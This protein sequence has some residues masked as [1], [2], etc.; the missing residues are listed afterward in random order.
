MRM[1]NVRNLLYRPS[2]I[3]LG[4][5]DYGGESGLDLS[6][7]LTCAR[8]CVASA[9]DTIKLLHSTASRLTGAFWYNIFCLLP[10]EVA[11]LDIY[12]AATVLLGARL[13]LKKRELD[14]IEEDWNLALSYLKR[15]SSKSISAERCLKVLEVMHSQI[16][17]Q[18][19]HHALTTDASPKVTL[20]ITPAEIKPETP[21][22]PAD[23]PY[24]PLATPAVYPG[25]QG[26]IVDW[27]MQDLVWSNLPWDWNLMDDLLVNG[28][29]SNEDGWGWANVVLNDG[30]ETETQT[31]GDPSQ[32][33]ET[34]GMPVL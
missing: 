2:L 33:G 25:T 8:F 3:L 4:R 28:T 12:T 6:T 1:L 10:F 20:A 26:N 16:S 7:T 30:R 32:Q 34:M 11:N 5:L 15:I 18:P 24:D 29:N 17:R 13:C 31:N 27:D 9:K 14:D 21:K 22:Q 19:P 23:P